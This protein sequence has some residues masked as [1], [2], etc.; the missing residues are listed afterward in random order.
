MLYPFS[1]PPFAELTHDQV[2]GT[3]CAYCDQP[4]PAKP[5]GS[6]CGVPLRAHVECAEAH[7]LPD[8]ELV[9]CSAPGCDKP[10]AITMPVPLCLAD[11]SMAREAYEVQNLDQAR[12]SDGQ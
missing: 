9:F 10:A 2:G 11:A 5:V 4:G 6:I 7:R 3:H 12:E 1:L 8:T